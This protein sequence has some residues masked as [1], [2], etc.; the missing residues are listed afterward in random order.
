MAYYYRYE[1]YCTVT[2]CTVSTVVLVLDLVFH[3]LQVHV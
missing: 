2:V 3:A 1:P